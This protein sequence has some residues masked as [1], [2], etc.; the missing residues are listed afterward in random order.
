MLTVCWQKFVQYI[1][2]KYF[3]FIDVF[4]TVCAPDIFLTE[5]NVNQVV[6]WQKFEKNPFSNYDVLLSRNA[7]TAP[8]GGGC[9]KKLLNFCLHGCPE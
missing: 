4:S 5:S 2:M 9:C 6:L 7:I 3:G 1:C 8:S